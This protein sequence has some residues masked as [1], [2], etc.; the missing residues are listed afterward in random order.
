MKLLSVFIWL[1]FMITAAFGALFIGGSLLS[2]DYSSPG[3]GAPLEGVAQLMGLGVLGVCVLVFIVCLK[4]RPRKEAF[5]PLNLSMSLAAYGGL[6]AMALVLPRA[7]AGYTLTVQVL[8][9]ARRPIQ[10]A[11]LR[12]NSFQLG[13]GL[14]RLA[15][16]AKG[17]TSTDARGRVTIRTNHQHRTDGF[18][19]K[20][21]YRYASF[22]VEPEYFHRHE[23]SIS[24]ATRGLPPGVNQHHFSGYLPADTEVLLTIYLPTN[25]E[26]DDLPYTPVRRDA[27]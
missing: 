11:Q 6:V 20:D 5:T 19:K 14:A 16:P 26:G 4:L 2:M 13:A 17:T 18:I 25:G 3:P 21:G 12:Y 23:L 24:W 8:D 15:A 10:D 22:I 7:T 27:K 9:S 1:F